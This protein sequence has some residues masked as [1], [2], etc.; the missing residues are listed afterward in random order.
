MYGN[1][2]FYKHAVP[3]GLKLAFVKV[4]YMYTDRC[5]NETADG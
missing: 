5:P 3:T 2:F 4:F 1:P